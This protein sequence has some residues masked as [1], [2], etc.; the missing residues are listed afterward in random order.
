MKQ[1]E[2]LALKDNELESV[3]TYLNNLLIRVMEVNPSLLD[4]VSQHKP[5][6]W[7]SYTNQE[8]LA[9]RTGSKN[10]ES[11][12]LHVHSKHANDFFKPLYFKY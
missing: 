11:Q 7:N 4:T 8:H 12:I 5:K 2:M 10:N 6:S 3:K 1:R 9:E